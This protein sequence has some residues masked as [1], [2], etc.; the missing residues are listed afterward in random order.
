MQKRIYAGFLQESQADLQLEA[1]DPAIHRPNLAGD[2]QASQAGGCTIEG[3]VKCQFFPKL[4]VCPS[5]YSKFT[6]RW[7]QICFISPLPGEIT[8]FD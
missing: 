5:N 4:H 7:F 2:L 3:S 8:Q 1:G 6:G